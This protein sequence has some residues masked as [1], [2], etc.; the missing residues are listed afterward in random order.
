MSATLAAMAGIPQKLRN[1][2]N[3]RVHERQSCGLP[4]SCEPAAGFGSGENRWRG[5]IR[6]I[7]PGGLRL[8]LERRFERGTG[9]AIQLARAG[10][11]EIRTVLVKVVHVKLQLDGMWS[12]GCKFISDLSEEEVER[13]LTA[14]VAA[15]EPERQ[16]VSRVHFQVEVAGGALVDCVVHRMR[17][18]ASWPLPAGATV[19]VSGGKDNGGPWKLKLS[20]VQC[21]RQQDGWFFLGRPVQQ[22]SAGALLQFLGQ[23]NP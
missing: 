2:F 19:T 8:I 7:S 16:L 13:L 1:H 10:A 6:D 18:P 21:S 20:V 11:D 4:T 12:L 15:P 14:V 9:L 17:V 3:C 23:K 5:E 22:P